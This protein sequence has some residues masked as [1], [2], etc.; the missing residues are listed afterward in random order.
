MLINTLTNAVG[1]ASDSVSNTYNKMT[2][3]VENNPKTTTKVL[4]GTGVALI[5]MLNAERIHGIASDLICNCPQ[6]VVCPN[7]VAEESFSFFA[8][9]ISST[10]GTVSDG[11]SS[12]T[13]GVQSTFDALYN[14]VITFVTG[15]ATGLLLGARTHAQDRFAQQ[16]LPTSWTWTIL[17]WMLRGR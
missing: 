13:Y 4:L 8:S 6:Q 12:F 5:C 2:K 9:P 10:L 7:I 15:A 16:Q 17:K 1:S 11:V 14:K 3:A